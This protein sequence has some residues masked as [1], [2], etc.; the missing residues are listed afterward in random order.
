MARIDPNVNAIK[1]AKHY[2]MTHLSRLQ[3]DVPISTRIPY[4]HLFSP[5]IFATQSFALGSTIACH[6]IH[7]DT[8]TITSLNEQRDRIHQ[9]LI[10]NGI[11]MATTLTL[12]RRKDQLKFNS[13]TQ[14][15]YAK[16]FHHDYQHAFHETDCFQNTYY[17][18]FLHRG[19]QLNN[20]N[21]GI[22]LFK[23]LSANTLKNSFHHLQHAQAEQ[24]KQVTQQALV[25]LKDY[26]AGLLG[27]NENKTYSDLLAYL[28]LPLNA[29]QFQPYAF[30]QQH[31]ARLLPTKRLFFGQAIQWLGNTEHDT[32]YAAMVSVK[33][34]GTFS[35][36]IA[37]DSL[38]TVKAEMIIT[39]HFFPI[40]TEVAVK[41]V[42][43]QLRLLNRHDNGAQS[44]MIG[45]NDLL[46]D[47]K[48]QQALS[49]DYYH[50]V[51]VFADSLDELEA[52]VQAVSDC[53]QLIGWVPVRERLGLQASFWSQLPG[54]AHFI[55]RRFPM[56]SYNMAD[57]LSLHNYPTGF[58]DH[59]HLGK[60][61]TII[62][63]PSNTPLHFNFHL[64]S[65]KHD[66]APGHTIIVGSN[67]SGK[68]ALAAAFH[69]FSQHYQ[70]RSILCDRDHSNEIYFRANDY[71]Y[72]TIAPEANNPIAL[73]PLQL[74]DSRVTRTFLFDWFKQLLRVDD[75]KADLTAED[76]QEI[77][78]AV[79]ANFEL[80]LERRRLR[81]L[82]AFFSM[83]FSK[84]NTLMQWLTDEDTGIVGRYAYLFDHAQHQLIW[85]SHIGLDLTHLLDRESTAVVTTLMMFIFHLIEQHL[86]GTL[87]QLWLEEG[88]RLLAHDYW[89]HKLTAGIPT[90]RKHNLFLTLLTQ[91]CASIVNSPLRPMIMDNRATDILFPNS[92][93]DIR[94]Y[95][96]CFQLNPQ[97]CDFIQHAI[98]QKRQFL[99]RQPKIN[100]SA[101]GQFDLSRL[102]QHLAIL[103]GNRA[104][105]EWMR[106]CRAQYGENAKEWMPHFLKVVSL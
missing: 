76:E 50:S 51:C 2:D 31:I 19:M 70:G 103:S 30:T 87:T 25:S 20:M 13:I 55:P 4:S 5:E 102:S 23:K 75:A 96:Q 83:R 67:G 74:P 21:R 1:N 36:S 52:N 104:S 40:E 81:Y 54:N 18:T 53:Y 7:H 24:L 34:T 93:A 11:N 15:D 59:N 106:E 3:L 29:G 38:L 72:F 8:R 10:N 28:A 61:L 77:L 65:H 66:P 17:L 22:N 85:S 45:L 92:A 33:S 71:D 86:D 14:T 97:E 39:H 16:Q 95:E 62:K 64:P 68:T 89:Q 48:S 88:W 47:L 42:K 78:T 69:S 98:S 105:I 41:R 6:G 82:L 80:P 46:N 63:T 12:H 101:I 57:L 73:N 35:S 49:G 9:L 79:Q 60:S 26:Q 99:Y 56:T 91:S 100:F 90:W 58:H 43:Q 84:R 44:F 37:L 27:N 32:R 94:D